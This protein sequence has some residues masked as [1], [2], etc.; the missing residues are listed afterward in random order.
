MLHANQTVSLNS[1]LNEWS[2]KLMT[3]TKKS[4]STMAKLTKKQHGA[5]VA[6]PMCQKGTE[7][8]LQSFENDLEEHKAFG[9]SECALAKG[10]HATASHNM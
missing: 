8:T 4:G 10:N 6:L 5:F 7:M 2:N 9:L 1:M 3:N